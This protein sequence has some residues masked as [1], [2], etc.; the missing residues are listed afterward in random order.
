MH[1]FAHGYEVRKELE[2]ETFH[3]EAPAESWRLNL[4]ENT[5]VSDIAT[6]L[7]FHSRTLATN[8][9]LF[10]GILYPH[11]QFPHPLLIL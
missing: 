7:A 2:S 4:T 9:C 8:Q 6:S 5:S 1:D 10:A 3:A 11:L